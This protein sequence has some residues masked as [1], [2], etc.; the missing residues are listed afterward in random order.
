M[1]KQP[2]PWE[3]WSVFVHKAEL[4]IEDRAYFNVIVLVIHTSDQTPTN[5]GSLQR[6]FNNRVK[7]L[8]QSNNALANAQTRVLCMD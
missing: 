5:A 1:L 7:A 8:E 2:N 4:P 6:I 3:M